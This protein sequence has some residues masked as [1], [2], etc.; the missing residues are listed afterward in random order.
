MHLATLRADGS[1]ALCNV[2]CHA[3]FAPDRLYFV[4][5]RDRRYARD[6]RTDIRVAGSILTPDRAGS[7][8]AESLTFTGTARELPE[9]AQIPGH[10]VRLSP[11]ERV[12]RLDVSEW[13]LFDPDRLDHEPR[14]IPASP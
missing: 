5:H 14:V 4:A 6:L 12:Y 8:A 7:S 10:P 9:D 2:R 3:T 13:T 11:G 1:P